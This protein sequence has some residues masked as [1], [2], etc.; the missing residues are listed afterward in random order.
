MKIDMFFKTEDY[1]VYL[2]LA[3]HFLDLLDNRKRFRF[4]SKTSFA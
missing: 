4:L 2:H 1:N 3:Y